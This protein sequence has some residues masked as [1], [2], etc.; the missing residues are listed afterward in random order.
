M[1]ILDYA[2]AAYLLAL[3]LQMLPEFARRGYKF[4][5][6]SLVTPPLWYTSNLG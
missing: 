4:L 1:E 2:S 6:L 5:D 3:K